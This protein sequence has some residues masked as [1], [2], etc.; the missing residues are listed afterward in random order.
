MMK[1]HLMLCG[2]AMSF[3]ACVG[4][5]SAVDSTAATSSTS[6]DESVLAPEDAVRIQTFTRQVGAETETCTETDGPCRVG[7][8][9]LGPHDTFQA[10]IE[11]CCTPSGGC[12]TERY[13]LC[14]C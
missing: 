2:I 14:G 8:C 9:E 12:E 13:R 11:V 7:G 5:Q 3:A 1:L 4:G 6:Q 10:I